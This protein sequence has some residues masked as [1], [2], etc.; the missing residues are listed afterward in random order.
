LRV[1]SEFHR[2]GEK[3]RESGLWADCA[4][5]TNVTE[6]GLNGRVTGPAAAEEKGKKKN[7]MADY[8][9][10]ARANTLV[11]RDEGLVPV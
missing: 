11:L 4:K 7:T 8:R 1:S 5:K 9:K 6:S 3:R 10:I 2:I